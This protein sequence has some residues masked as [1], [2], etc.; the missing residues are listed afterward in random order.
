M[1]PGFQ[2][3]AQFAL[4]SALRLTHN[5]ARTELVQAARE[6]GAI[7]KAGMRLV[8][9]CLPHF[10]EEEEAVFPALDLLPDLAQGNVRPEMASVLPLIEEFGLRHRNWQSEHRSI[11][12][13]IDALLAASLKQRNERFAEFAYSLRIHE[14]LEEEVVYPT[15]LVIGQLLRARL[16]AQ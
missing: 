14:K 2:W 10:E 6:P 12:S 15:V 16:A 11:T 4:P 7:G 9:L 5:G 1:S 3:N 8:S 13:A